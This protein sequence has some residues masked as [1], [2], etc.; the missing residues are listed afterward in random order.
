MNKLPLTP[1]LCPKHIEETVMIAQLIGVLDSPD[2]PERLKELAKKGLELA[3]Q[4]HNENNP[5]FN[6]EQTMKRRARYNNGK[7][8]MAK[9]VKKGY[10]CFSS[11][12]QAKKIQP[13][14]LTHLE[15]IKRQGSGSGSHGDKRKQA[16]K[17]ACRG[18]KYKRTFSVLD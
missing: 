6:Q 7:T 2:V 14:N 4:A 18:N 15:H 17:T 8:P 9:D 13:R 16:N 12:K 11:R 10:G 3:L 1:S 5:T